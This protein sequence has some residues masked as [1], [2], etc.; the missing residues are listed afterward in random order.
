MSSLLRVKLQK[1]ALIGPYVKADNAASWRE[2]LL[3]I[4]PLVATW[5]AIVASLGVS[6]LLTVVLLLL[7]SL[8]Y[9]RVLVLMHECGHGSLFRSHRLNRAFGFLFGVLSGMPQFVWSAHHNFHHA[10][11]GNWE[12]YRGPQ[13]VG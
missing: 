3:T 10:N 2:V 13:P 5:W 1:Q 12:R 9:M 7:L 6:L 8:F 11:N 4:V